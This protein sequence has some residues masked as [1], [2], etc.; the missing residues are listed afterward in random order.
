MTRLGQQRP[1]P[2]LLG[3]TTVTGT[4]LLVMATS[5]PVPVLMGSAFVF[6]FAQSMVLLTYITLRT[7]LSPDELLGRVGSTARTISL[8]LQPIGLVVGGIVIDATSG[9]TAMGLMGVGE[10][11]IC[12]VF[13]SIGSMRR[14]SS[15][16]V[17]R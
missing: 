8:G 3:G 7:N 6:G 9:S 1:A 2:L 13:A 12:G 4:M 15:Q 11:L 14:A 10:I 16:A 17:A 5:A